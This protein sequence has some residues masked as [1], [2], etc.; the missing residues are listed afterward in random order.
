MYGA[1]RRILAHA[2]AAPSQPARCTNIDATAVSG[3][4]MSLAHYNG[5]TVL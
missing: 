1:T 2:A 5:L 4:H 3:K